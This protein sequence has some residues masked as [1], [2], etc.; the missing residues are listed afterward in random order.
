M[1][2]DFVALADLPASSEHA[3]TTAVTGLRWS[4]RLSPDGYSLWLHVA[5]L[6]DGA[7][8]AWDG[9]HG[10]EAV[11]VSEGVLEIRGRV[12]PAGGAVIVEQGVAVTAT[13]RGRTLVEH[14]GPRDHAQP[15][16]GLYGPPQPH[17]HGVHVVGPRGRVASAP[18]R[19]LY[20]FYADSTC[21][22]CRVTLLLTERDETYVSEPHSHTQ[23]ELIY[24]LRG[25]LQLGKA[26]LYGPGTCLPFVAN[27]RYAFKAG[28]EGFAFLNYRRDASLHNRVSAPGPR[29][30]SGFAQGGVENPGEDVRV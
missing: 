9:D 19:P 28:P 30:E 10:D 4:R 21:P 24:V 11:H 29:L 20:R 3:P 23:D 16:D 15:Q 13:A 26:H 1:R 18:G 22:T 27:Q 5:E 17:G 6:D 12:C 14:F 25:G 7:T 8:L 2:T